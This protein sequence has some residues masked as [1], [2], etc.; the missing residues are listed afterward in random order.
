M[1]KTRYDQLVLT[2]GQKTDS[3]LE[4]ENETRNLREAL[5]QLQCSSSA[6]DKELTSEFLN[7]K[8]NFA[9]KIESSSILKSRYDPLVLTLGRKIVSLNNALEKIKAEMTV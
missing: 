1:M 5:E 9:A 3:L 7:V 8:E 6:R 2:S 4:S